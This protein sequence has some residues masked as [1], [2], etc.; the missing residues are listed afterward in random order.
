VER[1]VKGSLR[2]NGI[3]ERV[4]NFDERVGVDVEV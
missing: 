1:F 2:P 4:Y 3:E